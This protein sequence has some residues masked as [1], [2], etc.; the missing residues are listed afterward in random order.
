LL[1]TQDG[2]MGETARQKWQ[3]ALGGVNLKRHNLA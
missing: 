2:E 3:D 1:K